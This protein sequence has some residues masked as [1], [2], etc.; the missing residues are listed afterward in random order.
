MYWIRF[1]L[2]IKIFS[3]S[4]WSNTYKKLISCVG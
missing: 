2:I 4:L 1:V 3:A